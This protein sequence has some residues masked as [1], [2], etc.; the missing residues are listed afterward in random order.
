MLAP[1]IRV[2]EFGGDGFGQ[3][4]YP[5]ISCI[6]TIALHDIMLY[7]FLCLRLEGFFALIDDQSVPR[8]D[9]YPIRHDPITFEEPFDTMDKVHVRE[10]EESV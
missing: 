9:R 5:S 6:R 7:E 10:R 4:R 3:T 1:A 2:V 8:M